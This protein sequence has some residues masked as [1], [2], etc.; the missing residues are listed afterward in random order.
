MD[1]KN[2][3]WGSFLLLSNEGKFIHVILTLY[4]CGLFI[5]ITKE[6]TGKNNFDPICIWSF[7]TFWIKYFPLSDNSPC[8]M[9]MVLKLSLY[10]Y[11]TYILHLIEYI[12]ML[13]IA[14][15]SLINH[16]YLNKCLTIQK[17]LNNML[18][19]SFKSLGKAYTNSVHKNVTCKLMY[20][21]QSYI[22]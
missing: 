6:W 10:D 7:T 9:I 3:S 13:A 17:L 14:C 5:S 18:E 11:C 4:L 8:H 20:M 2:S 16:R 21:Y 19:S 15:R 12:L 22:Y 1:D